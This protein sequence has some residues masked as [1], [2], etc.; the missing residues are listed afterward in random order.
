MCVSTGVCEAP[1]EGG[2]LLWS[3]DA[4]AAGVRRR[5]RLLREGQGVHHMARLE[6]KRRLRFGSGMWTRRGLE[7]VGPDFG[8]GGVWWCRLCCRWSWRWASSRM[9][10]PSSSGCSSRPESSRSSRTAPRRA[11]GARSARHTDTQT[12]ARRHN[13]SAYTCEWIL[14]RPPPRASSPLTSTAFVL[15]FSFVV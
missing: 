11:N 5:H 9:T 10:A 15:P 14:A 4:P 3:G 1:E 12:H 2:L 7:C 6:I 8:L 13:Q